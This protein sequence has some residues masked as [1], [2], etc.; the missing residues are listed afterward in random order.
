SPVQSVIMPTYNRKDML[1]EAIDSVLKQ[2]LRELE[3]IV[4]DD[5][6]SDGTGDFVKSIPDE[7]VR[8]FRNEKNSGL[9]WNRN[10]GF[11]QARGKYITFLDD[12]DYYTDYEFFQKAA[13]IF[14]EHENDEVPIVMVYANAD[15]LNTLTHKSSRWN[16]GAPG[17]VKGVDDFILGKYSKAPSTFPAVFRA[18]VMR[19]AGLENKIIF[20][21]LTYVEAALQGD[22]WLMPDVIGV[23][24]IH[25]ASM[26]RGYKTTTPEREARHYETL[27]EVIRRWQ[28]VCLEISRIKG[29]KTGEKLYRKA[30]YKTFRYCGVARPKFADRVKTFECILSETKSMPKM[31]TYLLL[32]MAIVHPIRQLLRKITPLRNFYRFLKYKC[33]G[34]P[35]P[36]D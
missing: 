2:S 29:K 13:R 28:N 33:R 21:D 16:I 4:V 26:E 31:W 14:A 5:C 22:A 9:E 24:R 20:D 19:K 25:G 17:R 27:R 15:L 36:E 18:D 12:D 23:Y 7:R 11:R 6:S 30:A 34:L 32:K 3:V 1:A 10:F 35:Y 8:Y